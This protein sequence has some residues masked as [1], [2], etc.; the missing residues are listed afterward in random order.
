MAGCREDF[1]ESSCSIK[2]GTFHEELSDYQLV[3]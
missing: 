2:D 3:K 1:N